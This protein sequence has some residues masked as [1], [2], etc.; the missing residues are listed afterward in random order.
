MSYLA[1]LVIS[2]SGTLAVGARS[3]LA[4]LTVFSIA[5]S[6]AFGSYAMNK[7]AIVASAV[8]LVIAAG[9]RGSNRVIL[10]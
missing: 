9:R 8:L 7:H 4:S 2:A 6:L 1:Y 3:N 10:S 5:L